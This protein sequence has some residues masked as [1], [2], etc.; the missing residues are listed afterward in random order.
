[1]VV[2]NEKLCV[3][4]KV[5]GQN[6]ISRNSETID[7]SNDDKNNFENDKSN[8]NKTDFENRPQ[9]VNFCNSNNTNDNSNFCNSSYTDG[10]SNTTHNSQQFCTNSMCFI[11]D[12][13]IE[14][15]FDLQNSSFLL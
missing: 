6:F 9:D 13:S 10:N 7:E 14:K 8:D 11:T 2:E 15:I 5:E 3:D 1:L 4:G 12:R